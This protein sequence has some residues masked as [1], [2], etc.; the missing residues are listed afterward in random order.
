MTI[1]IEIHVSPNRDK[2][3][4]AIVL[5]ATRDGLPIKIFCYAGIKRKGLSVARIATHGGVTGG[6]R[7]PLR[8][9]LLS[10]SQS[11]SP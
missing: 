4:Y 8:P 1:G 9:S 2:D 11:V 7:P 5:L 6:R 10:E 3:L